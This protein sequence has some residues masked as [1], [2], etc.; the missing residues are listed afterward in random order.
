MG[1]RRVCLLLAA[2]V[3]A[4]TAASAAPAHALRFGADLRR[5]ANAQFGCTVIP[6]ILPLPSGAATCTW[7]SAGTAGNQRE[8]FNVPAGR[9]TVRRVRVKVGPVTGP[10]RIVVLRSVRSA[11]GGVALCCR[12]RLRSRA[13][14]PRANAV[15]TVRVAFAVRND[16]VPNPVSEAFSFDTL[17]LSVLAPG[18]PVPAHDTGILDPLA[19]PI[20]AAF[21]PA[22]RARQE[23]ADSTGTTG[24]QVLLNADW[25]PSRR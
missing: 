15:S 17:A 20:S 2:L 7:F 14:T 8:G 13:F 25:L 3:V 16:R 22:L 5:P 19:A 12:E 4:G 18:V 21:F 9:G 23:R 11:Q 1:V 10:M 24:F 6:G